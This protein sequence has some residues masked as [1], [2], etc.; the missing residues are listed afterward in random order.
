MSKI[1]FVVI[2]FLA[3]AASALALSASAF[4][5]PQ[6]AP[7]IPVARDIPYP[8]TMKLT[9]DATD[10]ERRIM[11]VQQ[12]IPVPGPGP[13]VL[14]YPE[15]LPGKHAP[16]GELEKVAGL[17]ITAGGKP[18]VWRRDPVEMFALHVDVPAGAK[19]LELEFQF[20][21]ATASDQGRIVMTREM[22]NLQWNQTAF[23]PAGWNVAN[24]MVEATAILPEGWSYGVALDAAA[25]KGDAHSFKP[26]SFETLVDSPMFAGRY[27]RQV[28][29]DPGGRSPV[30]LN[31]VADRPELLEASEEQIARHRALVVQADRLF[32]ARPFDR[33][34]F[35]LAL[36]DRMGGIGLE[37]HRSS[38][39]SRDPEYF[40][41]WDKLTASRGLLPHE[42][43]HSWNGKHRRGA[44]LATPDYHTPMQDSL[45]WV[46]EGQTQF[47]GEVLTA[48]SGLITR[49]EALDAWAMTAAVYEHRVGRQWRDIADTT[50]DPIISARKPKAWLSWQRNEDYYADAQLVWL[51]ADTLIRERTN[52]TKSL[53]DFARAFFGGQ[54][55]SYAVKPYVFEDVVAALNAVT[56]Y[57]WA[58]FLKDRIEGRGRP[59][60]LEGLRRGGWKLV[61]A[62]TPS[63]YQKAADTA[64]K[65]HDFTYSIGLN[66]KPSGEIQGVQ[67]EGPAFRQKLVVGSTVV[68]VDGEAYSESRM[69]AAITRA[70]GGKTPIQLIVKDGDRYRVVD[71]AWNGGL[72]YPRLERIEA[73]PDRLGALLA[74]K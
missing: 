44:D 51:E 69:K 38:E 66:L 43:V 1:E 18:V 50:N 40:T 41:S 14:L 57:D 13:M 63:A 6:P 16:R 10:V 25:K 32:G 26:V 29:L 28:D 21:S 48:R 56:P 23:Y 5:Q 53:D 61:Y 64:A 37:H 39:N 45:M 71:I 46:Y 3:A 60:P 20:L 17:K 11:T 27:Y 65:R 4:A 74:P 35:L 73:T 55:G 54:D 72:R 36:T 22:L 42:Y 70:K 49:Q 34:D 31:I 30:R 47:W 7:S 8:G 33:Y 19:A 68:A 59:A 52:D 2:R 67:W 9:V 15:W 24:I 62:E 12:T 58:G